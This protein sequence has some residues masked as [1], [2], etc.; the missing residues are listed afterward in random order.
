M[1]LL[2]LTCLTYTLTRK[3]KGNLYQTRSLR[4]DLTQFDLNSE[5]RRILRKNELLTL[6]I[7]HIPLVNYNWKIHSLGKNFYSKRFGDFTFSAQKIKSLLTDSD[8][9]NITDLF[10]YNLDLNAEPVGYSMCYQNIELL[11]YAYPFYNLDISKDQNLGMGMMLKAIIWAKENKKRYVYLGS[12]AEPAAK[13]KLQFEGIE[14]WD[15][16]INSWSKD[17]EHLKSLIADVKISQN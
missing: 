17:I 15:N 11:H 8:N 2:I 5:N 6:N 13:Y 12:A 9:T 10:V 14:W 4:I 7:L 16:N 3:A 1:T